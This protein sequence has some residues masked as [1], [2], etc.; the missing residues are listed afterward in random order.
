VAVRGS[1]SYRGARLRLQHDSKCQIPAL[2]EA[3]LPNRLLNAGVALQSNY[4]TDCSLL[5][6]PLN[7]PVSSYLPC[8]SSRHQLLDCPQSI[9]WTDQNGYEV[10]ADRTVVGL[11]IGIPSPFKVLSYNKGLS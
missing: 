4:I 1:S 6:S 10:W 8:P 5:S 3:S 9:S 11:S 7:Q 2:K